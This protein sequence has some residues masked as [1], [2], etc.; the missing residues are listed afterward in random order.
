MISKSKSRVSKG[1]KG[2]SRG[3]VKEKGRDET[4]K[5]VELAN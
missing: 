3:L 5:R 1:S 2:G 4:E